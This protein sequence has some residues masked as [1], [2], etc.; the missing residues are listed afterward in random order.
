MAVQPAL[1]TDAKFAEASE[2]GYPACNFELAMK[3][4]KNRVYLVRLRGK[5]VLS[6]T[7]Y[8]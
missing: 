2:P 7:P 4:S 5:Q 8:K 1:E 3:Q 6:L